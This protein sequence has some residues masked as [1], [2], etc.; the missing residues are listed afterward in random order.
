[1]NYCGHRTHNLFFQGSNRHLEA[2][3]MFRYLDRIVGTQLK[4]E[5]LSPYMLY[6]G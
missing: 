1:M 2:H 3:V 5:T 6:L 4:G